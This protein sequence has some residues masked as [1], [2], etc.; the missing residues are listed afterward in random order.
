MFLPDYDVS[1]AQEIMPAADLSQQISTAGMEASGTGNMKLAS[2][3]R[4]EIDF[5]PTLGGGAFDRIDVSGTLTL[6][7]NRTFYG[8]V[9]A[10]NGQRATGSVITVAGAATIYGSVAV[11]WGGGF[12]IG[13]NGDNLTFDDRVFP[14]IKGF[15]GAAP[16]QGTWREMPAS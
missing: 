12:T 15:G 13:S 3:A 4:L 5:R 7:G 8:L 1:I 14:L 9:Y 6:G 10:A 11:D 2:D 16:V